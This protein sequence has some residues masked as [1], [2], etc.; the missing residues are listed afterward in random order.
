MGFKKK[1]KHKLNSGESQANTF[2]T[3][4]AWSAIDETSTKG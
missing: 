1:Q 2:V 4:V 3:L